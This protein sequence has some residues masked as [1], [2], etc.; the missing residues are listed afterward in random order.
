MA[1][2]LAAGVRLRYFTCMKTVVIGPRPA[3]E[4]LQ[5]HRLAATVA[6]WVVDTGQGL[7][8]LPTAE[9]LVALHT[10]VNNRFSSP[11]D[12]IVVPRG[13]RVLVHGLLPGPIQSLGW[14]YPWGHAEQI[15]MLNDLPSFYEGDHWELA[16]LYPDRGLVG[17]EDLVAG[18]LSVTAVPHRPGLVTP[19]VIC[20]IINEAYYLYGEGSATA[21]A[22]DNA[23]RLGVNYPKGPFAW[24]QALGGAG[25]VVAVLQSLATQ[26]PD[27]ARVAP[28]LW[29][30]ATLPAEMAV[31]AGLA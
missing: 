13:Y 29:A 22:I 8:P 3:L 9:R 20:Q 14:E 10:V 1:D 18:G 31:D 27:Q 7:G 5:G 16:P 21:D 6:E 19:R 28:A 17:M 23:M 11:F 15:Y 25:R 30:A 2:R 24:A 26:R 4:A 12:R